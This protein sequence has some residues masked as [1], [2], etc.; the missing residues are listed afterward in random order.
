VPG[1]VRSLLAPLAQVVTGRECVGCARP[2]FD[3]CQGCRTPLRRGARRADP[4]PCPPGLPPTYAATAYEGPVREAVVA[5]KERGRT[6]LLQPLADA[7][8]ASVAATVLD[9]TTT[10]R[11]LLLVPV[12]SSPDAARSRDTAA[13]LDLARTAARGLCAVGLPARCWPVVRAVRRRADQT[14][15]TSQGRAENLAG[16]MRASAGRRFPAG[17][18][19][20]I[21]DDVV[22]TGAT[23]AEAA[24]ALRA[25]G[26]EVIG[27]A[28]VAATARRHHL[29]PG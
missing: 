28:V 14:G 18:D 24:R 19:V 10:P 27:C 6:G 21:V 29:Q 2:G 16:S 1:P 17:Y 5:L 15:L 26:I 8:T 12:P 4:T 7:L 20:V 22:T 25:C 11:S 23:L 9:R 13:T 3:L